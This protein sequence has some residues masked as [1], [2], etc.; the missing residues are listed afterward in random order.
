MDQGLGPR[1]FVDLFGMTEPVRQVETVFVR[2]FGWQHLRASGCIRG[3]HWCTLQKKMPR[4][5][6]TCKETTAMR[7][8]GL[9]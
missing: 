6:Q 1:Q 5:Y 8:A 7:V 9:L 4:Y 2:V 3:G